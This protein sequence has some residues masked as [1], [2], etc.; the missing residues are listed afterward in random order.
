VVDKTMKEKE[1]ADPPFSHPPPPQKYHLGKKPSTALIKVCIMGTK[2]GNLNTLKT[3]P[4]QAS[5]L[6][7]I[8]LSAILHSILAKEG[9]NDE[10]IKVIPY[11]EIPEIPY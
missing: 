10:T 8:I 9:N 5:L 7:I 4:D 1:D 2:Q 11:K 3:L 6:R